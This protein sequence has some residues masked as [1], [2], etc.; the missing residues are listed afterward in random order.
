[1]EDEDLLPVTLQW[2]APAHLKNNRTPDWYWAL[3]IIAVFGT[4]ASVVWGNILFASI[5]AISAISLIALAIRE[6]RT[7]DVLIDPDGIHV[8]HDFYPYPS[9]HSFWVAEHG[10]T[11]KLFLSTSGIIHPHVIIPLTEDKHI[12]QVRS[13]LEHYI[14]EE[15][16]HSL[17]S[18]IAEILGF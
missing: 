4:V 1:M 13:Y 16:G 18:W 14:P 7:L 12:H 5:I 8:D 10:H 9:L 11:P 15:S 2:V 6:P 17:G 3:G